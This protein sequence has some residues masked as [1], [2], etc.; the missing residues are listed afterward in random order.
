MDGLC[1]KHPNPLK[2]FQEEF[3]KAKFGGGLQDVWLA[4][5]E[6]TGWNSRNLNHQPSDFNQ[7]VVYTKL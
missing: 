5:D 3:L 1:P 2:V 6:V 4:G 7:C